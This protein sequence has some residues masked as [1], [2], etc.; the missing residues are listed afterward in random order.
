MN[1]SLARRLAA[2][3]IGTAFLL[4][5]VI[6][7]GIMG[8]RLSNGI[9][10]IALLANS[11]ATGCGLGVL[12]LAF[13]GIS[14]SH[15]NPVVTVVAAVERDLS[16][17]EVVPYVSVQVVAAITGVMAAHAMF[18]QPALLSASSKIRT[19][20]SQWLA[21]SIATFGLVLVVLLCNRQRSRWTPLAVAA[22]ITAAYWFTSSTSFANPAA[23]VARSLSDTYA[24]IRPEDVGGF[25]AAQ[26]LGATM[27][28]WV[29]RFFG[30]L[31]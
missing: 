19:G 7:S 5:I 16:W 8:D 2:E 13:A 15:F 17:G 22:Y 20:P 10:A 11:L 9:P 24:G 3:A 6:G 31:R 21:E 18:A 4:A 23:T 29:A 14:G 1:A 28:V 12:I 26:V 30:S 25:V 27:G